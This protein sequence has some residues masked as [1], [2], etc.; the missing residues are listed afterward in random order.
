VF[1]ALT[2]LTAAAI[3]AGLGDAVLTTTTLVPL[4]A[5]V[6]VAGG[7]GGEDAV[8][9]VSAGDGDGEVALSWVPTLGGGSTDE[10]KQQQT[11]QDVRVLAGILPKSPCRARRSECEVKTCHKLN[12]V[13]PCVALDTAHQQALWMPAVL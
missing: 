3:A 5:V 8:V 12:Q 11:K 1:A 13:L 10:G 7:G 9:L 2:P 4:A 6:S